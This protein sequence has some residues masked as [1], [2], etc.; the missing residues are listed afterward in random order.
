MPTFHP[1]T[2]KRENL[3]TMKHVSCTPR[4]QFLKASVCF[5]PLTGLVPLTFFID[6]ISRL[7]PEISI[8]LFC[9]LDL[10][11]IID[12]QRVSRTWLTLADDNAVWRELFFRRKGWA[13]NLAR[14]QAR[15]WTPADQCSLPSEDYFSARSSSARTQLSIPQSA[16]SRAASPSPYSTP[17]LMTPAPPSVLM[18][19]PSPF[20]REVP[21]DEPSPPVPSTDIAPLTLP[22]RHI[23]QTRH[24]LDRRWA[25]DEYKPRPTRLTGH[26]DSVYCLEFDSARIV[27]GS[28]DQT[29]RVWRI[30]DGKCIGTFRGHSGSVLCLKFEKDWDIQPAGSDAEDDDGGGFMVSGSSDRT[31]CVWNMRVR[32]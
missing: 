4:S 18:L 31:V 22:W 8:Y 10:R 15:G 26:E 30:S 29:V 27:T 11:S 19:A 6:I 32:D 2:E 24:T 17:L 7:P 9:Y 25:T 14:A 13:I 28:R 1:L 5:Q 21:T 12:C 16:G 23:Y 20:S 3:S